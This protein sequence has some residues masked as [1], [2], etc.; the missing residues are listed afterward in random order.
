MTTTVSPIRKRALILGNNNY[1][2][3]NKLNSCEND[4]QDITERLQR[5]GFKVTLGCNLTYKNMVL[6]IAKFTRSIRQ[7]DLIIFFFSGHGVQWN[8][9]NYLV[10]VDNNDFADYPELVADHAISAQATLDAM[11]K[12]KPFAVIFLLDCCRQ[13]INIHAREKATATKEDS[14]NFIPMQSEAGSLIAFACG[15]NQKALDHSP[16]RRNSLFTYHLLQHI[17]KPA[18][19]VEDMMVHVCEGV[20]NDSV[21]KL[22]VHRSSSLSV[23]RIYLN[24]TDEGA[25][26]NHDESEYR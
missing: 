12:P 13:P 24:C 19:R 2:D 5:I 26:K 20:Y 4:A 11:M 8:E 16:N 21:G 14:M 23:F 3:G 25:I 22:R 17:D 7:N 18:L 1:E 15:P 10:A 9:H 6:M